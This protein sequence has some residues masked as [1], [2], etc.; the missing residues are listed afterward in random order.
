M[1]WAFETS[2]AADAGSRSGQRGTSDNRPNEP[3]VGRV[4]LDYRVV[5]WNDASEPPCN[6]APDSLLAARPELREAL[7]KAMRDSRWT[8]TDQT[9]R[10]E[11]HGVIVR[12]ADGSYQAA[13]LPIDSADVCNVWMSAGTRQSLYEDSV[14]VV[15]HTHPATPGETIGCRDANGA[16]RP[17][18][19]DPV[20]NQLNG[21]P[22]VQ[23]TT[24]TN[25]FRG[26]LGRSPI[27][28]Y[29]IDAKNV[30]RIPPTTDFATAL[31]L[32]RS[33]V[34]RHDGCRF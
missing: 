26:V 24:Q 7:L 29:Y 34:T 11:T 5:I 1:R 32:S 18:I 22:D 21:V 12:R 16:R 20:G 15:Y 33:T 31:D 14:V 10:R 27:P 25:V 8:S 17:E 9:L 4:A 28:V 30:T 23:M 3:L 19:Y 6:L 13:A 2:R